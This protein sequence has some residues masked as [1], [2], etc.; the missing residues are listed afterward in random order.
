MLPDHSELAAL[1]QVQR[2]VALA[3][4][5]W[6]LIVDPNAVSAVDC[7][8]FLAAS[9]ERFFRRLASSLVPSAILPLLPLQERDWV[10][11][12]RRCWP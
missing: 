12:G 6:R 2:E 10:R 11:P 5:C 7:S 9:T 3:R 8:T 4:R 1:Q